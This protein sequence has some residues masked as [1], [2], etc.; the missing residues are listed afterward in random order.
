MENFN[1]SSKQQYTIKCIF[2]IILMDQISIL[3]LVD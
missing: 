3:N 1:K 2:I